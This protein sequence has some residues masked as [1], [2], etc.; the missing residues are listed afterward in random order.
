MSKTLTV[1]YRRTSKVWEKAT[2]NISVSD[3]ADQAEIDAAVEAYTEASDPEMRE[4]VT[5]KS[6][7][8]AAP[9]GA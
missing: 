3:D 5:S 6:T 8:F 2:F 9:Y 4:T 1:T 7:A